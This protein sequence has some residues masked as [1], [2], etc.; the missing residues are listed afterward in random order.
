VRG[1]YV[2]QIED[3]ASMIRTVSGACTGAGLF[4]VGDAVV[5]AGGFLNEGSSTTNLV[6]IHT[7]TAV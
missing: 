6:H 1:L 5:I 4:D 7:V 2:P 3:T